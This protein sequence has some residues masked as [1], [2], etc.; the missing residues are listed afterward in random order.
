MATTSN[1]SWK[2]R[3]YQKTSIEHR[4][5]CLHRRARAYNKH[6]ID[7]GNDVRDLQKA[8]RVQGDQL[9]LQW[10]ELECTSTKNAGGTVKRGD[11]LRS[12]Y[13]DI[14]KWEREADARQGMKK[15][16]ERKAGRLWDRL[17]SKF[18]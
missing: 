11:V 12:K 15:K 18:S 8:L 7:T 14:R 4:I 10:S 3:H 17:K 6:F 16:A 13:E 5:D 2:P 9:M 1:D